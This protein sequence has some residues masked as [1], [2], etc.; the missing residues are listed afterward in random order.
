MLADDIEKVVH[1]LLDLKGKYSPDVIN[2]LSEFNEFKGAN[3]ELYEMVLSDQ[4]DLVVF[5]KMMAMKRR[6]E[7]GEDQYSVDVK[8][9]KFMAEK[10]IEPVLPPVPTV[11]DQA[12]QN[13]EH[14][15][16]KQTH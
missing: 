15:K 14:K 2:N 3:K 9:G 11:P 4:M 8:F 16:R 13:P 1:R 12:K 6:L 10:Y 7:S 5:K